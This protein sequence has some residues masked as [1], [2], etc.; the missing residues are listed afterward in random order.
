MPKLE[1]YNSELEFNKILET[2]LADRI[3]A[4]NNVKALREQS[5]RFQ[6]RFLSA[7]QFMTGNA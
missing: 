5:A 2:G 4:V 7:R 1:T 3:G 6:S